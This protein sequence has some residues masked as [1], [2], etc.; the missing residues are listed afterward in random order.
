MMCLKML[1]MTG[2]WHC[3][4]YQGICYSE[5]TLISPN[6]FL[7]DLP[8]SGTFGNFYHGD[9]CSRCLQCGCNQLNNYKTTLFSQPT[10]LHSSYYIHVLWTLFY[11]TCSHL[12]MWDNCIQFL[13]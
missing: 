1:S 10:K 7:T 8:M 9:G 11:F 2:Y 4:L 6:I 13:V 12:L 3:H 5:V